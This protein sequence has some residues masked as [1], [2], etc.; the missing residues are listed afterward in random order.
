MKLKNYILRFIPERKIR[1]FEESSEFR[2]A[3]KISLTVLMPLKTECERQS[4]T[5]RPTVEKVI[6]Y[7]VMISTRFLLIKVMFSSIN[8]GISHFH[9]LLCIQYQAQIWLPAEAPKENCKGLYTCI[10][11]CL[12][13]M[14]KR[15]LSEQLEGAERDHLSNDWNKQV[16]IKS[17]LFFLHARRIKSYR[18]R[19]TVVLECKQ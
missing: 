3:L 5:S 19:F 8:T 7:E 12:L 9:S 10:Q 1:Q 2:Y 16:T 11:T 18:Q 15:K 14:K 6:T 17:F 13:Y 4:Y